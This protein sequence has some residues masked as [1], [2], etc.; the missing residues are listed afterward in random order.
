MQDV[1]CNMQLHSVTCHPTQV[2]AP[3]LNPSPQTSTR[4]THPGGIEDWVDLG[5]LAMQRLGVKLAT[6]RYKSVPLTT[7]PSID[8]DAVND[9]KSA[10][11]RYATSYQ[12]MCRGAS[13]YKCCV[14]VSWRV[15]GGPNAWLYVLWLVATCVPECRA[16]CCDWWQCSCVY[17][18]LCNDMSSS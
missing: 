9:E 7:A 5:Y 6:S 17:A 2:N 1:T 3:H 13:E 15:S 8:N 14:S 11:G 4:F 10:S 18:T 16:V 12:C